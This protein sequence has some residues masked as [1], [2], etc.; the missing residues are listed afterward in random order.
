MTSAVAVAAG[1]L[2][3]SDGTVLLGQRPASKVY[4][5]YWEFPGGKIEPGESTHEALVRELREELGIEV[6]TASPWLTQTFTYPHATV[7]LRFYRVTAWDGE[8]QAR[9]HQA[10]AWAHPARLSLEPMLPANSPI[11]R[12]LTLPSEYAISDIADLGERA[13]LRRL[14]ERVAGG[15]KLLQL[16]ARSLARSDLIVLGREVMRIV[17]AGG[18]ACLVNADEAVAAAIDADGVHLTAA[19]LMSAGHRPAF[20]YVGASCHNADE[21]RRAARLGLDFA[22]LGP[23]LPTPSHVGQP[24]IGWERF[25]ALVDDASLPV[26]AM[27]GLAPSDLQ[28]ALVHG[29]HGVA[30][31]RN[32]W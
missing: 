11:L 18:A 24:P 12:A 2:T 27:G 8:P 14:E 3:R 13:F 5:G 15:L 21:L 23:V 29:A 4:A 22:V 16:R 9:E 31:L 28:S 10:L 17:R 20:R 32:A 7:R 6:R 30:M 25:A 1:I 19:A 26:F